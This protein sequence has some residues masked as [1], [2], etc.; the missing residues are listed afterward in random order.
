MHSEKLDKILP[1][2][3]KAQK[4]FERAIK[5]SEN[6]HFKSN[7]AD[8]GSVLNACEKHLHENG[9]WHTA[10][11]DVDAG[12]NEYLTVTVYHVETGQFFSSRSLLNPVKKDAQTMGGMITYYRRYDLSALLG[13]ATEEDDDGNTASK[14]ETKSAVKPVVQTGEDFRTILALA[15]QA[16]G[17]SDFE[18]KF[19]AD[20]SAK[21][22]QYGDK[23]NPPTEKQLAI[24]KKC[25][26]KARPKRDD[27]PAYLDDEIPY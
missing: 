10:S 24:M 13:L 2:I 17:L 25:A 11:R 5:D 3:F 26:D 23:I 27:V 9:L 6:P 15:T 18:Q 4:S 20:W 16:K 22:S 1:A 19:L 7:Y 21:I 12:L 14:P 8:Y